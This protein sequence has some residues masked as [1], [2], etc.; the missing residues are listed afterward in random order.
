MILVN[1]VP[2]TRDNPIKNVV[3]DLPDGAPA[4]FHLLRTGAPADST[5]APPPDGKAPMPV[6]PAGGELSFSVPLPTPAAEAPPA[7]ETEEDMLAKRL[8]ALQRK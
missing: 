1:N 8:E 6:A 7:R 2:I 3:I 4:T 5:E